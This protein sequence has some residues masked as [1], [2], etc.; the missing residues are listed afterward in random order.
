MK[1][2]IF[3]IVLFIMGTNIFAQQFDSYKYAVIQERFNFQRSADQYQASTLVRYLFKKKGFEVLY[4]SEELPLDLINNPCL[5]L[6]VKVIDLGGF[7]NTSSKLQLFDCRNRMVFESSA[8]KT[9]EKEYKKAYHEVIRKNFDELDAIEYSYRPTDTN[10]QAP[11]MDMT[12][13]EEPIAEMSKVKQA[14]SVSSTSQEASERPSTRAISKRPTAISQQLYA[15]SI[16]NGGYQLVDTTPK[17][18][19]KV[20]P[21]GKEDVYLIEG[22]SAVLLKEG[23]VWNIVELTDGEMRKQVVDIKF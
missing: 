13:A 22:K 4:D 12:K 20:Y 21:S 17:V 16:A 3:F 9:K 2:N 8:A 11:S 18:V 23:N 19:M 6:K 5:G 1:K 14:K 15:Q 7:L 10:D